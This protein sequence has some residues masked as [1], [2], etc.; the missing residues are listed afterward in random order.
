MWYLTEAQF[1]SVQLLSCVFVTHGLQHTRPPCVSPTP[2]VYSNS[3]PLSW[4][5][6]LTISSS[7]TPFSF[8]LQS[9]PASGS[10]PESALRIRWTKYWRLSFSISL[11]NDYSGLISFRLDL[12][13]LLADQG[14]LNSLLQQHNLKA[15]V[16][17]HSAYF[18]VQL[19]HPYMTTG[20]TRTLTIWTSVRKVMSW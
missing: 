20:E 16:L 12:F 14:T 5:C 9:F 17:W 7:A 15:S 11:S 13:D 8:C 2:G 10:F 6:Y 19:A 4:W 3:C 1:S 18:M